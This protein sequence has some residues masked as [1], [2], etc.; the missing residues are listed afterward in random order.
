MVRRKC[1]IVHIFRENM[2]VLRRKFLLYA[3]IPPHDFIATV[4]EDRKSVV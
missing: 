1:H 2:E 3:L 4:A